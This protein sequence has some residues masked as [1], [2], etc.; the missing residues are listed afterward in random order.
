M[1]L[2]FLGQ[3]LHANDAVDANE[4]LSVLEVHSSTLRRSFPQERFALLTTEANLAGCYH[5]K[6]RH[7][8]ALSLRRALYQGMLAENGSTQCRKQTFQGIGAVRW[9]R[10]GHV[11]AAGWSRRRRAGRRVDAAGPIGANAE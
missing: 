8:E 7:S 9:T 10:G 1:I 2:G 3:A 5:D 4:A 11:D 6:G